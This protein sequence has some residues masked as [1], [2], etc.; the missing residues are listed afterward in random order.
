MTKLMVLLAAAV[1]VG[2]Q[3]DTVAGAD[4]TPTPGP[5]YSVPGG[6]LG[7]QP[8]PAICG[9]Q[10]RACAGNWDPNTGAWEFPKT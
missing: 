6:L 5:V 4:P 3:T 10:P 8:L 7:T 1:G 9:S 2:F